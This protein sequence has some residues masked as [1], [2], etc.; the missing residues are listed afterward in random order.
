MPER[1]PSPRH[2][3]GFPPMV[4]LPSD[5]GNVARIVRMTHVSS[6]LGH[7]WRSPTLSGREPACFAYFPGVSFGSGPIGYIPASGPRAFALGG[8]SSASSNMRHRLFRVTRR[9]RRKRRGL[10]MS[11]TRSQANY[12]LT[13]FLSVR[14]IS[15]KNHPAAGVT[16]G[17]DAL[18]TRW[19]LA[20]PAHQGLRHEGGFD[21][22]LTPS[23][24]IVPHPGSSGQPLTCP[25]RPQPCPQRRVS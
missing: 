12:H 17:L 24:L 9:A 25:H 20:R 10:S 19:S 5:G 22:W 7:G 11:S 6:S 13:T 16:H 14:R 1:D 23:R 3:R 15:V 8:V 4:H 18:L 2:V 21:D